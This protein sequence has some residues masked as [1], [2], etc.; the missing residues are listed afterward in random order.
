[1]RWHRTVCTFVL[2]TMCILAIPSCVSPSESP[3]TTASIA[4]DSSAIPAVVE[5]A[6]HQLTIRCVVEHGYDVDTKL[7]GMLR[8][9]DNFLGIPGVFH[10]RED[11]AA[12]GYSTTVS[13]DGSPLVRFFKTLSNADSDRFTKVLEGDPSE[14]QI[15]VDAGDA[16]FVHNSTGCRA[17]ALAIVFGDIQ[18]AV[19]ATNFQNAIALQA[20]E[21]GMTRIEVLK[22]VVGD[23]Q[24]CMRD[25][26]YILPANKIGADDLA[27]QMFG[28]YR[29]PGEYPSVAEQELVLVDYSCQDLVKLRE[30]LTKSFV[31]TR[32]KWLSRQGDEI[33]RIAQLVD[34]AVDRADDIVDGAE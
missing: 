20:S 7:V 16:I 21:M 28:E 33:R 34:S 18:D 10:S 17:E 27:L 5:T 25:S 1:M 9:S 30:N 6:V 31:A 3:A 14:G 29:V 22:A 26:G 32:G 11:A 2:A 8:R 19:V 13:T 24:A 12:G 23:Y 15:S 4:I